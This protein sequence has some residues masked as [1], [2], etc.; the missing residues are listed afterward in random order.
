MKKQ[1]HIGNFFKRKFQEDDV[2]SNNVDDIGST[3][4]GSI[5]SGSIPSVSTPSGSI[6]SVSMPSGSIPNGF[7]LDDLPPDP[8]DRPPIASYHPNH[9]CA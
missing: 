3:P 2:G 9:K 5:P 7:D 8:F 4:S 6:P 1:V